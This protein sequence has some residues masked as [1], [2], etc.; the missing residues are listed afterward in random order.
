MP[1]PVRKHAEI[2]KG[3]IYG[4]LWLSFGVG[5]VYAAIMWAP[6]ISEKWDVKSILQDVGNNNWRHYDPEIVKRAIVKRTGEI[7]RE[8]GIF[9]LDPDTGIELDKDDNA[10]LLTIRVTWTRRI[11]WPL[12]DKYSE[13]E[14]SS[15]YVIDTNPVNWNK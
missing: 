2:G 11:K 1:R 15:E 7:N 8:E 4:L 9:L 5:L 10:K 14:Y 6:P 12:L 13:R 3:S